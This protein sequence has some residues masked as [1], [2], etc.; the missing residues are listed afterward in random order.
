MR[1]FAFDVTFQN[2]RRTT[3]FFHD[4][5]VETALLRA[6]AIATEQY[7]SDAAGIVDIRLSERFMGVCNELP[8]L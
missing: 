5:R 1:L 2:G 3:L 6:P 8:A 7:G 4:F